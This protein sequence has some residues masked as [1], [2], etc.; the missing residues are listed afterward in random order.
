MDDY[1]IPHV[2]IRE[3]RTEKK[4]SYLIEI[5]VIGVEKSGWVVMIFQTRKVNDLE[6]MEGYFQT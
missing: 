6:I 4:T 5:G 2:D 1:L 3:I